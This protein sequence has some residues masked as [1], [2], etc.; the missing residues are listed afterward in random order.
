VHLL[1]YCA[2]DS[3]DFWMIVV[4]P[5]PNNIPDIQYDRIIDFCLDDEAGFVVRE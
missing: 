1:H 2:V 4:R 5:T 3:H